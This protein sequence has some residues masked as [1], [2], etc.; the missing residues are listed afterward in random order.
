VKRIIALL[1][2]SGILSGCITKHVAPNPDILRVGISPHSQPLIFKQN[3]VISG[4]EADFSKKLGKALNRKVVF[5]EVPWEKQIDYLE[6]N[7]TDII[8]SGMTITGARNIRINFSTPYMQSGMSGLFRRN[9]CNPSGLIASTI[10]NQSK[11]VGCVKGTTGEYFVLQRF[12]RSEKKIYNTSAEATSALKDGRID[13]FIYDAPI[14]WWLSAVNEQDLIAFPDVLN[15]EP[16]A[17]GVRKSDL[18][19]LDQVNALLVQWN[20]DGSRQRIIQNWIPN[21]RQ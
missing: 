14:I 17:W 11:K 9:S 7:K 3:G 15:I 18:E 16:L 6:Q 19:L 21:F 5:I 20:N 13:M 8:M 4:I 1:A 12:T 2:L 10:I